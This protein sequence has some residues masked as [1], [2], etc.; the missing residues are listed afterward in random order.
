MNGR[1]LL[2]TKKPR[3]NQKEAQTVKRKKSANYCSVNQ[4]LVKL[5][6]KPITDWGDTCSVKANYL[7]NIGYRFRS[8]GIPFS[9]SHTASHH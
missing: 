7:D 4:L 5:T 9:A 2:D 8:M 3:K 1:F 6:N